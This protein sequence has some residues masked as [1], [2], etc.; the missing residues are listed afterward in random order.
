MV[1]CLSDDTRQGPPDLLVS[2]ASAFEG[3]VLALTLSAEGVNLKECANTVDSVIIDNEKGPAAITVHKVD[4]L[5][6]A[7]DSVRVY[8]EIG[9]GS[10]G[11]YK[12]SYKCNSNTTLEGLLVKGDCL[13]DSGDR[14]EARAVYVRAA[15]RAPANPEVKKRLS[16]AP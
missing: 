12:I 7:D 14:D 11:E 15:A 2:P 8:I 6:H 9:M 3:D 10:A 4:A 16:S 13:R 1:G 5:Q